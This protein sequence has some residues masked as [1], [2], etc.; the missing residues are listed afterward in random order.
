[1]AFLHALDGL[2]I[3]HIRNCPECYQWFLH[4]SRKAKRYCSTR[5]ANRK[6]VRDRRKRIKLEDPETYE[7]ELRKNAERAREYYESKIERGKP[8]RRPWKYK[9]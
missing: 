7:K 3:G 2:I 6:A 9:D 5:C 8:E 4:T 1:L